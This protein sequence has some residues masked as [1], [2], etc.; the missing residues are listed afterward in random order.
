MK[1]NA[2]LYLLL[3]LLLMSCTSNQ[4]KINDQADETI[5]PE[6]RLEELG[7]QLIEPA[8]PTA[9]YVMS[10]Q[11][12]DLVFLAGHGPDKPGGGKVIGKLGKDLTL[13]Q[14]QEAARLTGVSLLSSLK[15]EIGD[16]IK[17]KRIVKVSGMVNAT[18]DFTDHSQVIN[19]FSDLMVEVFGERGKHA[20][21]AVGMSSLP[22]NI[23]VEIDMI[24]QVED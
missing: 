14:G 16:L 9:N 22:G 8:S 13:E 5:S 23:P 15:K 19:G 17:V 7:I 12:E 21:V 18:P 24:V 3:L 1:N 2:A 10:V 11:H 4:Q 20:R 6:E